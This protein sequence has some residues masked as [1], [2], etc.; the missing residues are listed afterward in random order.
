MGFVSG[1][2]NLASVIT[3]CRPSRWSFCWPS[4]SSPVLVGTTRASR[5]R[6]PSDFCPQ[7]FCP[8][9]KFMPSMRPWE[10]PGLSFN[11]GLSTRGMGGPIALPT[12]PWAL[13]SFCPDLTGA[14]RSSMASVHTSTPQPRFLSLWTRGCGIH[15]SPMTSSAPLR[16]PWQSEAISTPCGFASS[17]PTVALPTV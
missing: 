7:G 2:K 12:V 5:P 15:P 9:H 4:S 3:Q 14:S 17:K 8:A 1:K 6:R 13:L 10:R 16:A 11:A